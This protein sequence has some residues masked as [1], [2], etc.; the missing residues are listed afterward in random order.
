MKKYLFKA[1]MDTL[2]KFDGRA[3]DYTVGR[4]GCA[5]ELV[6]YLYNRFEISDES[7]IADIGSGTGKFAK[8]LLDRGSEVYCVEP[9]PDMR[10]MA[11]R[12]LNGYT[13]FHSVIGTAENT[14]YDILPEF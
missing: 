9:N 12:E 4:P 7:V 2:K 3:E 11:E 13:N 14:I 6:D 8:Y 5:Q 1:D 10:H